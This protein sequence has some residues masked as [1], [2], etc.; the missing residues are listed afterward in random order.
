MRSNLDDERR[1]DLLCY[2]VIAQLIARART[3]EWLRT[4]HLVESKRMWSQAN[5]VSPDWFESERLAHVCLQ[6]AAS[7]WTIELL[8]D[9]EVLAKMFTDAWRL[10]YQSPIVRGIS[11]VCTARLK[12]WRYEM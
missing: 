12:T 9:V 3:N 5:G 11:D 7:V 8:Q 10:D 2:L 6:L 4:D 1:A